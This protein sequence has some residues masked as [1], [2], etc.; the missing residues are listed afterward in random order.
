MMKL[1]ERA[2]L[3]SFILAR[4]GGHVTNLDMPVMKGVE[5]TK[6]IR[7]FLGSKD[8]ESS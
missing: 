8:Y 4:R 7:K 1:S 3:N 5:G 6:Q 2:E